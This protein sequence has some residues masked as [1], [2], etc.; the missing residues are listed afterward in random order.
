[1][2]RF[3]SLL[4][5]WLI[6]GSAVALGA[7]K[8]ETTGA[9]TSADVPEAVRK[10][11]EPRGYRVTLDDGNTIDL[12]F[13]SQLPAA[14]SAESSETAGAVYSLPMSA[15]VGI[16]IYAKPAK[17]YRNQN[18]RPGAYTL[19]Y[20]LH[21]ADGNHMGVAPSR[22]F[23][24]M[25]P[26]ASDPD[27]AASFKFEELVAMSK[28]AA[29]VNHPAPLDL[30]APDSA[31]NFPSVFDDG[32]GHTVLAVKLKSP[33]GETPLALVVKGVSAVP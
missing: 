16:A 5:V 9:C 1:M 25:V 13:R 22:D 2:R 10:A 21:P 3:F 28:K 8:L 31:Q 6:A 33:T 11:L 23:V 27:P 4:F 18:I 7:G 24:L 20:A 17:D 32:E 12:W 19:R 26:A 29:G 30:A 15:F 14:R